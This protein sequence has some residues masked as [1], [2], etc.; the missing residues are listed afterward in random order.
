MACAD[1]AAD[2]AECAFVHVLSAVVA[3]AESAPGV[4][5][6]EAA[7]DDPADS[8]EAGAVVVA[9]AGDAVLD[10]A[11]CQ[12][13]AVD[14]EVVAAVGVEHTGLGAWSSDLA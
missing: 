10:A 12:S 5:P 8:A 2:E 13:A 14:R 1:D 11:L 7:F 9:A 3:G 6:G 4:E